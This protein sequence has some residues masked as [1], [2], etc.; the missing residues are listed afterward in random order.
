MLNKKIKLKFFKN[1]LEIKNQEGKLESKIYSKNIFSKEVFNKLKK[2]IINKK[3]DIFFDKS[4]YIKKEVYK[5]D[6]FKIEDYIQELCVEELRKESDFFL[7]K[8]YI[9]KD[10][11]EIFF[12]ERDFFEKMIE[13]C[14]E[15]KL[16]I[17]NI[18]TDESL[19]YKIDD[20]NLILKNLKRINIKVIIFFI[21]LIFFFITSKIY[22]NNLKKEINIT[23]DKEKLFKEKNYKIKEKINQN[24]K[25]EKLFEIEN[26]KKIDLKR[27]FFLMLSLLNKDIF[28]KK[29]NLKN[30]FINIEGYSE[31]KKSVFDFMEKV[32]S[33]NEIKSLKYDYIYLKEG[34]YFFLFE[35][36]VI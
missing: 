8:S 10:I 3:I 36:E 33:K 23:E 11:Y 29:Y 5:N 21:S 24:Q 12:F 13:L 27:N 1:S 7:I 28:I 32:K 30:N 9:N 14:I 34:R 2:K 15:K 26:N 31:N 35:I 18:Y 22:E 25:E 4:V 17:E 6:I 20:Y 16:K 19:K